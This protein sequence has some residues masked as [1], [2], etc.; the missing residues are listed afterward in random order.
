MLALLDTMPLDK[1][2]KPRAYALVHRILHQVR[3]EPG[4]ERGLD[5]RRGDVLISVE[6]LGDGCGL[7]RQMVRNLLGPKHLGNSF[8]RVNSTNRYSVLSIKDI[9]SYICDGLQTNPKPTSNQPVTNQQPTSHTPEHYS[10]KEEGRRKVL[11]DSPD[12]QPPS[13]GRPEWEPDDPSYAIVQGYNGK[14]EL[15][16][17][18]TAFGKIPGGQWGEAQNA[19]IRLHTHFKLSVKQI[20]EMVNHVTV[21][22][23]ASEW[24]GGKHRPPSL[25]L[26]RDEDGRYKWQKIAAHAESSSNDGLEEGEISFAA[27]IARFK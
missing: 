17:W 15:A 26:K 14:A 21:D 10:K 4:R 2:T 12:P 23:K 18:E 1:N 6:E 13:N 22:P 20:A 24:W 8:L 5:L 11:P 27:T 7:S 19:L 25:W 3:R 9:D 16:I